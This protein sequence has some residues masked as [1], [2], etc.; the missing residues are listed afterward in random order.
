VNDAT[1]WVW[2]AWK[3]PRTFVKWCAVRVMTYNFDG[4]LGERRCQ[5]ALEAWVKAEARIVLTVVSVPCSR[6]DPSSVGSS[7]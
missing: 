2:L 1:W 3:L 7:R 5:E 6:P 4:E